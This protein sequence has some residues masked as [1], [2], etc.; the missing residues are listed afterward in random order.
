[1]GI[2]GK[3]EGM[4]LSCWRQSRGMFMGEETPAQITSFQTERRTGPL[5]MSRSV[6]KEEDENAACQVT[7]PNIFCCS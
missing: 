4:R 5:Q 1:M 2:V 6:A 7:P 3:M